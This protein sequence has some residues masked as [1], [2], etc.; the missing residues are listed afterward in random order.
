[1]HRLIALIFIV[2]TFLSCSPQQDSVERIT[3]DGVEV[4]LNHLEPYKIKGEPTSLILEEERVIDLEDPY[5][6]EIGLGE[7]ELF[8]VDSGGNIYF[9][10]GVHKEY[11][12]FKFDGQGKLI[13]SLCRKGQGPQ[14]VQFVMWGGIDTND[15]IAI[16]DQ[17]HRKAFLFDNEGNFKR[18]SK[19]P[20]GIFGLYPLENGNYISFWQFRGELDPDDEYIPQGYSLYNHNLEEI[21]VLDIYKYPSSRK[22]GWSGTY[23]N[24]LFI[25]R[26]EG[27]YIYIGNEGRGY[28]F[29]VYDLDGN[30]LRKI[31]KEYDPVLF[32]ESIRKKRQARYDQTG[33][34][35]FFKKYWPPYLSFVVDDE[36]RIY[37]RTYEEGNASGE[38]MYDIFNQDGIFILRK[39]MNIYTW[40]EI[41][42][43]A[44]VKK[45]HLYCLQEKENGFKK[46]VIY[47]MNWR[48]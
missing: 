23:I 21:K 44:V 38:F 29:L 40:G 34:K 43:S 25:W 24:P 4:V 10:T 37:A 13:G 39:S 11:W 3:E 32:P 41:D 22:K 1:M 14:E 45:N 28:E 9:V 18:E 33:Q 48:D 16:T 2:F 26:T 8:A 12:I 36:G 7:I 46:L 47:K 15:N 27:D 35:V 20:K 31:R 5:F 6:A 30:L 19:N 42:L 17:V